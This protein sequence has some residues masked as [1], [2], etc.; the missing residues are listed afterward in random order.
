MWTEAELGSLDG[1]EM[2]DRRRKSCK[3]ITYTWH[4]GSKNY[5]SEIWVIKQKRQKKPTLSRFFMYSPVFGE[6]VFSKTRVVPP[7]K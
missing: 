3:C 7:W 4:R 2:G 5:I 6:N 1:L